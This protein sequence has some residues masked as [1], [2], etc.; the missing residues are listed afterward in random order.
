MR[1]AKP[2]MCGLCAE[3]AFIQS[4]AAL[5]SGRHPGENVKFHIHFVKYSH[6][7]PSWPCYLYK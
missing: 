4:L 3:R 1:I 2:F 5:V 7:K 6:Q